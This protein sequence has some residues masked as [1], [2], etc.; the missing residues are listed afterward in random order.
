MVVGSVALAVVDAK[1]KLVEVDGCVGAA[2]AA[3]TAVLA[4]LLLF[5]RDAVAA[6][7][8]GLDDGAAPDLL[9]DEPPPP[10]RASRLDAASFL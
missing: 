7:R 2:A 5:G 4:L 8:E 1:L 6:G 3:E 10:K 9:P